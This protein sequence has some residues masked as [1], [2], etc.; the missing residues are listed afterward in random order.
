MLGLCL[1]ASGAVYLC[2]A[3]RAAVLRLDPSGTLETWFE[4]ADGQPFACP[5]WPA[6]AP[7]GSLYVS[8]SGPEDLNVT[9][10]PNRAD[11]SEWRRRG[12]ARPAAAPLSEWARRLGQRH[13]LPTRELYA[14]P[15]RS[16][17]VGP[18]RPRRVSG[19]RTRRGRLDSDGGYVVSCYYHI[20]RVPP[21]GGRPEL[22]LNDAT[23]T[24]FPMPTNTCFFG[25]RRASLAIASLGGHSLCAVEINLRGVVPHYPAQ[26]G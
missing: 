2:D 5:N 1:D 6:F 18:K 14:A 24:R 20:Y 16:A 26:V 23:G 3:G 7:D 11:P 15:A 19:H 21:D 12:C 25:E 4:A 22:L 10:R 9:A 13:A 8:D 17:R